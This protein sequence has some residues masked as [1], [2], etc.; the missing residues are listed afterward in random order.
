MRDM[1]KKNGQ[2]SSAG[3]DPVEFLV[4]F[5]NTGL[6]AI[7]AK[8]RLKLCGDLKGFSRSGLT[9]LEPRPDSEFLGEVTDLRQ[10]QAVFYSLLQP[11]AER[12]SKKVT[13][14][15]P[16][17]PDDPE[18]IRAFHAK[19]SSES[20]GAGDVRVGFAEGP[21]EESRLILSGSY[22]HVLYVQAALLLLIVHHPTRSRLRSCPEC[23]AVF[24]RIRKQR[25]C[26]RRCVNR[27][28]MRAWLRVQAGKKSHQASS[29]RS[30]ARRV[31]A[32]T[33]QNVRIGS[34]V[35]R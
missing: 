23:R 17:R 2:K 7:S 12:Q 28:N 32:D 13:A 30:Y 5:V 9:G 1:E 19:C 34:R 25:Y 6:E 24:L 26:S 11:I 4:R 27:A 35:K 10:L 16:S 22:S 31:H 15:I 8:D 20:I 3:S 14:V 21:D 29:R 33:S 18:T